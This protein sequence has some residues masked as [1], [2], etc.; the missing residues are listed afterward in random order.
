MKQLFTYIITL[1][2][3]LSV[4]P[5]TAQDD[6]V[7]KLHF[8]STTYDYGHIREDGGAVSCIFTAT[9]TSDKP[10]V[11]M[12]V[13]TSCGCTTARYERRPVEA[14]GRFKMELSYDPMNRPGRIDRYIYVEVSDSEQKIKLRITGNV[15]PRNRTVDEIYPFDMGGGLRLQS[16]F[17]AFAY[18]EHGKEVSTQ[19][20]YVNNS[21]HDIEIHLTPVAS[22]GALRTSYSHSIAPRA[23]GDIT[24]TYR[25]AEGSTRYGTLDDRMRIVVDGIP[26]ETL[27]STYAI[28]VDNFDN[29]DDISAP[30]VEVS[31]KIIKFGEVNCDNSIY[32][33]D[34]EIKNVGQTPLIVRCTE[35]SGDAVSCDIARNV[36]IAPGGSVSVVVRLNTRH[37]DPDAPYVARITLITNDPIKPMQVIRI[38]ALPE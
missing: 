29:T 24:L 23:T 32:K 17:H 10:I 15:T 35:V 6:T 28:A 11:V 25:L 31:K 34:F 21:D 13:I 30:R 5:T 19:I 22:S 20:G 7:S 36:A 1:F 18:V 8:D 26:S 37:I 3:L 12:N 2:A 16:N 14:G 4:Q 27:L 9:N 33:D 38:S